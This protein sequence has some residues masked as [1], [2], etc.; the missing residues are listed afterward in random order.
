MLCKP[1]YGWT[2]V[3]LR[4]KEHNWQGAASYLTEVHYDT[5][6]CF[7]RFFKT[8]SVQSTSYDAEGWEFIFVVDMFESYIIEK[9]D[10]VS[11]YTFEVNAI[12]LANEL[13]TDI[14]SN[15][16]DWA[17]FMFDSPETE[18]GIQK[19]MK[20]IQSAVDGLKKAMTEFTGRISRH[21]AE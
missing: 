1:Q 5:I 8:A 18:D 20:N 9:K 15:L 14:E 11:L 12:D 4:D 2:A 7:T 6:D 16:R 10:C 3:E 17:L 21:K 19:E 13:I